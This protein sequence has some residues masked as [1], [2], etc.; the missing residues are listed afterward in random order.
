MKIIEENL[1]SDEELVWCG[2]PKL[3]T[4]MRFAKWA[5]LFG[6]ALVV[7]ALIVFKLIPRIIIYVQLVEYGPV[8][9]KEIDAALYPTIYVLIA[10]VI[11][12]YMIDH[13][14]SP[15]KN[16]VYAITTRRVIESKYEHLKS[17]EME[18]ILWRAVHVHA[19]GSG[20]IVFA[21]TKDASVAP[22]AGKEEHESMIFWDIPNV[23]EVSKKFGELQE[24][25][26]ALS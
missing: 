20:T 13:F 7:I 26:S 11:L 25:A 6:W 4:D 9:F 5:M 15:A 1:A 19:D 14:L 24:S 16:T 23:E 8:T 22:L 18:E 2:R 3:L 10:I 21:R 17:M 12:Y